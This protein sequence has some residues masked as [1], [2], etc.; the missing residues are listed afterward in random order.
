[1]AAYDQITICMTMGRRPDH[2][3]RTIESLGDIFHSLPVIAIND[4]GDDE[5]SSVYRKLLPNGTL[6]EPGQ[7]IGHHPAVDVM[8]EQVKT[9]YIFHMEDDWEFSRQNF[10][11]DALNLLATDPLISSVCFREISDFPFSDADRSRIVRDERGGIQFSRLDGLHEEWH[12]Y[13]FNPHIAR[14]SLWEDIGKFSQFKKERHISRKLRAQ[15]RY[16]AFL[17]PGACAHIGFDIS[18]A[19]KNPSLFKRMKKHIRAQ[20][21]SKP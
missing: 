20:F 14:K 7:Q 19:N 13:T 17:E 9:P 18:V 21:K 1:M 2:L 5:T 6:I 4:F 12:A 10:I 8:Y 3:R 16:T 11:E 15:G